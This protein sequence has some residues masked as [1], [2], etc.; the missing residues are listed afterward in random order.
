MSGPNGTKLSKFQ[1]VRTRR[2]SKGLVV[3]SDASQGQ[4]PF[5]NVWNAVECLWEGLTLFLPDASLFKGMTPAGA[6]AV[7]IQNHA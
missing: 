4:S 5:T 7:C 6:N 3:K 1:D 2:E